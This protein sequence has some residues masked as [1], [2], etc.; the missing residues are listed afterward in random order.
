MDKS[1]YYI[2]IKIRR[3]NNTPLVRRLLKEAALEYREDS[4]REI[5]I[6]A[7]AQTAFEKLEVK[8]VAI[9]MPFWY[10]MRVEGGQVLIPDSWQNLFEV[11]LKNNTWLE[12][13]RLREDGSYVLY[14][15]VFPILS[16]KNNKGGV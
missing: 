2:P 15:I 4:Q 3:I 9:G 11:F 5:L 1:L 8:E 16:K 14:D 7:A 13:T 6:N 12:G 10:G